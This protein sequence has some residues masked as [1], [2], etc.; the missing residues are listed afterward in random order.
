MVKVIKCPKCGKE[1]G[2]LHLKTVY[3]SRGQRYKYYY[4]GHYAGLSMKGTRKIDW[5][6]V[7]KN[8]DKIDVVVSY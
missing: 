2:S 8:K 3:N 6:Y 1:G 4:V 7:G 5:C